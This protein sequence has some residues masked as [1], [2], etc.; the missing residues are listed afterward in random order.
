MVMPLIEAEKFLFGR[1]VC[2]G[3]STV[4]TLALGS[5]LLWGLCASLVS[6]G[7]G[8]ASVAMLQEAAYGVGVKVSRPSLKSVRVIFFSTFE[9]S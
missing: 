5:E 1:E 9:S 7:V 3:S 2:T 6:G 8:G 4:E